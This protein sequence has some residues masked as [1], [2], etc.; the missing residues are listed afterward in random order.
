M[1]PIADVIFFACYG[2]LAFAPLDLDLCLWFFNLLSFCFWV[3]RG[4]LLAFGTVC[5][6]L[7]YAS[8]FLADFDLLES[9]LLADVVFLF[10]TKYAYS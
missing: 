2:A 7:R 5:F 9:L 10:L 1:L 4:G 3:S 8:F 6:D